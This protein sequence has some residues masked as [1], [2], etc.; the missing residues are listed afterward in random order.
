MLLRVCVLHMQQIRFA[1]IRTYAVLTHATV[2]YVSVYLLCSSSK[3]QSMSETNNTDVYRTRVTINVHSVV[4]LLCRPSVLPFF[5]PSVV[6]KQMGNFPEPPKTT[7]RIL[8]SRGVTMR[9]KMAAIVCHGQQKCLLALQKNLECCDW[10][11]MI[12]MQ[13]LWFSHSLLIK[14]SQTDSD[15]RWKD[16]FRWPKY[17]I[18]LKPDYL[19]VNKNISGGYIML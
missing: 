9:E 4:V 10:L 11:F 16:S 12:V 19:I 14:F 1:T 5:T 15:H 8:H 18:N 3:C 2:Q 7:E 13:F 17:E 6:E